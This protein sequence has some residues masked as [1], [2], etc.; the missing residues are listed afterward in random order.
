[1]DM[2]I[3][4]PQKEETKKAVVE[5]KY[6]LLPGYAETRRQLV[7]KFQN[8]GRLGSAWMSIL[9]R[10]LGW[11]TLESIRE[12]ALAALEKRKGYT[13][14]FWCDKMNVMFLR[15]TETF[16]K[17]A[18]NG[19]TPCLLAAVPRQHGLSTGLMAILVAFCEVL[20]LHRQQKLVHVS[21]GKRCMANAKKIYK[22]MK[23]DDVNKSRTNRLRFITEYDASQMHDDD[24]RKKDKRIF[25]MD[26][27]FNTNSLSDQ[28]NLR[29]VD[30]DNL[31][32]L[33]KSSVLPW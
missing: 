16:W 2:D 13:K 26:Y 14:H 3:D 32:E 23:S 15:L 30:A 6:I 10:F 24:Q 11:P 25:F 22:E 31:Y 12:Y 4:S 7:K 5:I 27:A 19:S 21:V 1:M 20:P 9:D 8:R 18:W 33:T 29:V 28:N 17:R